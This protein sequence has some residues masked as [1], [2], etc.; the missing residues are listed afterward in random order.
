MAVVVDWQPTVIIDMLDLVAVWLAYSQDL[1]LAK[2]M[3]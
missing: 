3:L 2:A 1:L